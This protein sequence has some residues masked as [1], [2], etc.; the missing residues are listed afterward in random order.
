[1]RHLMLILLLAAPVAAFAEGGE[2]IATAVVI[3]ELPCNDYGVTC[4]NVNDYDEV[5]P[6]PGSTAPDVVY[7]YTPSEDVAV[8]CSLCDSSYDTKL[9]VYADSVGHLVACNDDDCQEL[10]S[11]LEMTLQGG[12]TYYFVVDGYGTACGPYIFHLY[13]DPAPCVVECPPGSLHEGEPPCQEGYVDEYNSGCDG[14]G[15]TAIEAQQG[16]CAD[17]CGQLCGWTYED[18]DADWYRCTAAGGLVTATVR[19]EFFPMLSLIYVAD[20]SPLQYTWDATIPCATAIL[21]REFAPGQEFW[22]RVTPY[23]EYWGLPESD[24]RLHVCGIQGGSTPVE[25]TSW[26]RIKNRYR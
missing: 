23:A 9:Y 19:G 21:E 7:S 8:Y 18:F 10:Q 12:V 16:G 5:C 3:P 11:Y 25:R 1:M 17:M 2:T 15:W 20:C 14:T 24:Y 13:P 22:I 26:G 4:D 6:F